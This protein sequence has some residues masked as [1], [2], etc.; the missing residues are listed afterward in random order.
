[1]Y[2]T[3]FEAAIYFA[4]QL[5]V[6]PLMMPISIAWFGITFPIYGMYGIWSTFDFAFKKDKW[7]E[8]LENDDFF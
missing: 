1:M 5:I 7:E 2:M 4:S 8:E 6:I 3:N